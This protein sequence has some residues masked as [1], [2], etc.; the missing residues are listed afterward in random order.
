M[1]NA[2][3][4][5]RS[6]TSR[7]RSYL[8]SPQEAARELLRRRRL[9]LP[10]TPLEC[11]TRDPQAVMAR[12]GMT[13]DSW[14]AR[15]L[16]SPSSRALWLASRQSGKSQTVAAVGLREAL[17]RPESLILLLSPTL[18]QSGELFR[19]KVKRLYNALD[20]PVATVQETALTVELANGSRIISLPGDEGTIRGYSGVRLLVVDE[21]A[22][23]PDSLYYAVR[24][25]LAVS[26]GRM[27][28]LSSAWA[29]QG[30]FYNAWTTGENWE[31][32]KVTADQCPRI[33]REFLEQER[34]AIGQRWF[35]MEYMCVFGDAIDQVFRSEDLDAA[36]Q[37]GVLPLF[38]GER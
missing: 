11:L 22:R 31:R 32:V 10:E 6:V 17:T 23:V 12:A 14:Q 38:A 16:S 20:R 13:P 2:R 24:P 7:T 19:D 15:A 33:G 37:A 25:M 9:P 26:K 29:K 3:N 18:R 28:C 27:V 36:S 34:R 4:T 21:A 8:P 30:W 5:K 1:S 35:D